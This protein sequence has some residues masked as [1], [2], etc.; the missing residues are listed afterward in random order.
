MDIKEN[1]QVEHQSAKVTDEENFH[2][3]KI[4]EAIT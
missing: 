1:S 3:G 2:L 4:L